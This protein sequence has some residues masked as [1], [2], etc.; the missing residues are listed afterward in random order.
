MR[1]IINNYPAF[2]EMVKTNGKVSNKQKVEWHFTSTGQHL[3]GMIGLGGGSLATARHGV[4]EGC[5]Q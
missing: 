3:P 2:P 5:K 1:R 4:G